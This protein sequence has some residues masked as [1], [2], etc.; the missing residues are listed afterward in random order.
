MNHSYS[1]R[2]NAVEAL[3]AIF[4]VVLD[5]KSYPRIEVVRLLDLSTDTFR[6]AKWRAIDVVFWAFWVKKFKR[7]GVRIEDH[8]GEALAIK[9]S[10]AT[11]ILPEEIAFEHLVG[12]H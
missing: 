8:E 7:N 10:E 6:G 1:D 11:V 12:W 2:C 3:K 4:A 9:F 5:K